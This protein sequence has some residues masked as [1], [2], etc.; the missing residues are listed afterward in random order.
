MGFFNFHRLKSRARPN[1][2]YHSNQER[3]F[4]LCKPLSLTFS[5]IYVNDSWTRTWSLHY[6][7][8]ISTSSNSKSKQK[9][10]V[11]INY[12]TN[13]TKKKFKLNLYYCK[14]K[15]SQNVLFSNAS[16]PVTTLSNQMSKGNS[17]VNWH[18]GPRKLLTMLYKHLI[19]CRKLTQKWLQIRY[20]NLSITR[21]RFI[22]NPINHQTLKTAGTECFASL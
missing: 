9:K 16:L 2:G 11:H 13:A 22:K 17:T 15:N 3:F 5:L 1:K 4:T 10:R 7:K 14:S 8:K 20:S 19:W 6:L 18:K 12:Y 21:V